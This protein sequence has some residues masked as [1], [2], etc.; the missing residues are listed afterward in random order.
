[1]FEKEINA[2]KAFYWELAQKNEPGMVRLFLVELN[3]FFC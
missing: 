1:M 2:F 3:P